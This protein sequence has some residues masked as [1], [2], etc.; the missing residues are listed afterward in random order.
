MNI[1]GHELPFWFNLFWDQFYNNLSDMYDET[2]MC[3]WGI[4]TYKSFWCMNIIQGFE[5]VP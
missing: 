2:Q 4:Q 3:H 1:P 5:E